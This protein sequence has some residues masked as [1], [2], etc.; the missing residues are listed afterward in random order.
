MAATRKKDERK[1][2]NFRVSEEEVEVLRVNA[3]RAGMK[4]PAYCKKAALGVKM[5]AAIIDKEIA[6]EITPALG[7]I[8]GN[9][10][11][12]AKKANE[13]GTVSAAELEK[14]T[15]EFYA[16]WDY[17]QTGKIPQSKKQ[18]PQQSEEKRLEQEI[19]QQRLSD[20]HD[21]PVC[22]KC[23]AQLFPGHRRR[24]GKAIWVCPNWRDGE[25]GSHTVLP[26]KE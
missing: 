6:K 7:K 3:G 1:Q 23:G 26:R 11:Q 4:I 9:I 22:Q 10:N 18:Q 2:I 21:N 16:L 5:K 20:L 14:V 8:G 13:G 19:G 17:L 15:E 12:L 25:P 24:D